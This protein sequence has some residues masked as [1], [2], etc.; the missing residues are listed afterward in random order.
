MKKWAVVLVVGALVLTACA[1]TGGDLP[2]PGS[3]DGSLIGARDEDRSGGGK[4]ARDGKANKADKSAKA[5][6]PDE[7]P[8]TGSSSGP[9]TECPTASGGGD[10]VAQLVDVRVGTHDGY[11]RVAFEFAPPKEGARHF[12]VPRYQVTA[13]NGPITEDPSGNPVAV[14]G[15][16]YAGIVLHGASGVEFTSSSP[17]GYRVT[18]SGPRELR[19]GFDV[20]A[21][22][23][24][25]GD[26]EAT[27]SW[28]FGLERRSCW[29]A[30]ELTNPL[31]VVIDFPHA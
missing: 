4:K 14:N 12:G 21:E 18:Y 28:A 3:G 8:G 29:R 2:G 10:H 20:L 25:T 22:A 30:F 15:S 1:G 6:S 7:T 23:Q 16:V 19:P 27:L 9:V 24:Q 31:R 17:E 5:A 26:F 11:D 13:I